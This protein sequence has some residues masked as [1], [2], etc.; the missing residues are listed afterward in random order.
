MIARSN[1]QACPEVVD[2]CPDGRLD[3]QLGIKSCQ[4][5]EDGYDQDQGRINPVDM[6]MPI[7]QR[8]RLLADMQ[9]LRVWLSLAH[10]GFAFRRHDGS[11]SD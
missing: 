9:L 10:R 4:A 8:H 5:A 3:L 1:T 2:D 7:T 6:M 11:G